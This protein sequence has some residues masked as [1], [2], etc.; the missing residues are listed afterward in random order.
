MERFGRNDFNFDDLEKEAHRQA[1]SNAPYQPKGNTVGGWLQVGINYEDYLV[2]EGFIERGTAACLAGPSGIGK[3]SIAIQKAVLWSVGR[4]AFYFAPVRPLRIVLT[5]VEDSNNDVFKQ[6]AVVKA[7]LLNQMEQR[8]ME[9]NLWIEPMR[10]KTGQRA[11]DAWSEL[12]KWFKADLIIANP[13]SAYHD[14]DISSNKDN[15]DF[16]YGRL[17]SMLADL[18]VGFD[19]MHHKTKP[20]QNRRELASHEKMYDML[21]GSVLTNFHRAIVLVDPVGESDVY[22]FTVAKRFAE[23]GW[24]SRTQMFKWDD[25]KSK[26][27]WIPASYAESK[28]ARNQGNSRADLIKLVPPTGEIQKCILEDLAT[29]EHFTQKKFR[30]LL[31]EC[32]DDST[33][34]NERLYQSKRPNPTGGAKVF[35]SRTQFSL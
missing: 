29:P 17:A 20:L 18:R 31:A 19:S 28:A 1:I 6:L 15:Q 4:S 34:D 21:G 3:S 9:G 12:C 5:Q 30:A 27:L 23:S 32:L 24:T 10:G 8:T 11:I 22:E 35:I 13:L 7:L 14:G 33:P 16:L 26:H 25:D 2:G